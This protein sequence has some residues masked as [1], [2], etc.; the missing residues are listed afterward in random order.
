MVTVGVSNVMKA[1]SEPSQVNLYSFYNEAE[2]VL[3]RVFKKA[4]D[5]STHWSYM[6]SNPFYVHKT[7][8]V[9]HYHTAAYSQCLHSR[10]R[11]LIYYHGMIPIVSLLLWSRRVSCAVSH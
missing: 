7:F 6:V 3:D 8:S 10:G 9:V 4:F 2:G 1:K 5:N 11:E